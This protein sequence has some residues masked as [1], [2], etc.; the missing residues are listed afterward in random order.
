MKNRIKLLGILLLIGFL[1]IGVINASDLNNTDLESANLNVNL[2]EI[3]QDDLSVSDNNISDK[4]AVFESETS[5]NLSNNTLLTND[6]TNIKKNTN[7]VI[8][9]KNYY[10]GSDFTVTLTDSDGNRISNQ[11]VNIIIGTAR[12]TK[13]TNSEGLANLSITQ[14][15]GIY[16][17]SIIYNG[18]DK[19]ISSNA[20]TTLSILKSISSSDLKIYY[21]ST[22]KYSATFLN[23][24]GNVLVNVNV[25]F[26]I[27]GKT[28]TVKTNSKGI[29]SLAINLKPGTYSIIA[30]NPTTGYSAK[31]IIIILS[32]IT[33]N[34]I[35]KVYKDGRKFTAKFY[36]SNGK[37]LAKKTVKFKINGKI[38]NV[39]TNS[40]GVASLKLTNLKKRKL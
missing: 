20:S 1:S 18:N 16:Q 26:T 27:N 22:T 3:P 25:T 4:T 13:T 12:Y 24:Q 34:D 37:V 38:Y 40:Y 9:N 17:T 21:K 5:N 36:K 33:A 35:S 32:T 19:Y 6:D 29:A 15:P 2:S 23:S 39:K 31:N 14:S 7:V 28:S 11:T 10:T 30:Y 8:N